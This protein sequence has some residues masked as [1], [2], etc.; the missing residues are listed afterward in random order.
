MTE[1]ITLVLDY[2]IRDHEADCALCGSRLY[3]NGFVGIA[4]HDSDNGYRRV[5]EDCTD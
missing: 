1:N 3:D 2:A 5:C 4:V